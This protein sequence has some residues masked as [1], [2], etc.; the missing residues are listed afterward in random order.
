MS[1]EGHIRTGADMAAA[2]RETR[3]QVERAVQSMSLRRWAL[4][5]A[6]DYTA[7]MPQPEKGDPV[8]LAEE[9]IRFIEG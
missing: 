3:R 4:Q 6:L 5:A 7:K 8:K 1:Q 9:I 2:E